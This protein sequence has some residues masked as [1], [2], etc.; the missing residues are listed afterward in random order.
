MTHPP[1]YI[2]QA[3]DKLRDARD[4]L[5]AAGARKATAAVRR[6]ISSA[7]GARRHAELAPYRAQRQ[8]GAT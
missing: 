4:L 5:K 8:A 6:A 1:A 7:N 2:E 3:I